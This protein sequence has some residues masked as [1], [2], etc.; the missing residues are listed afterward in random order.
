[1]KNQEFPKIQV[2]EENAVFVTINGTTVYFEN[3]PAGL[4]LDFW[5]DEMDITETID[6]VEAMDLMNLKEAD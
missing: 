6:L 1:M 4:I 2:T 5:T 3:G